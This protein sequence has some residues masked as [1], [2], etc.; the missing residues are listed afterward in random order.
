MNR[1][2]LSKLTDESTINHLIEERFLEWAEIHEKGKGGFESD[3]YILNYIRG[4]IIQLRNRRDRLF[5]APLVGQQS[6]FGCE[7]EEE[8][9]L[10]ELLPMNWNAQGSLAMQTATIEQMMLS[11]LAAQNN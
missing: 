6:L 8:K 4:E 3:G 10:P 5:G 1:I 2:E 11:A 7:V 9:P